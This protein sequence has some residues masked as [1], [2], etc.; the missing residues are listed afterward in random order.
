MSIFVSGKITWF[1]AVLSL[2]FGVMFGYGGPGDIEALVAPV[3]GPTKGKIISESSTELCWYIEFE[4][5]R[6]ATPVFFSWVLT[7]PDGV[8]HYLAPYR[9]DGQ[10]YS[11]NTT[12]K[13]GDVGR[14]YNCA[15]K[16]VGLDP[17]VTRME[18]SAYG[19]YRVAHRMWT[20]PR[21]I[22]PFS[23]RDLNHGKKK[24][25]GR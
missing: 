14:Y 23:E 12:S 21:Y 9:P 1:L 20:V 17:S 2:A 16:P 18:L 4:K 8:R 22:R 19:E 13:K 24:D 6:E 7:T 5:K 11:N 10:G 3:A 15:R 25:Q